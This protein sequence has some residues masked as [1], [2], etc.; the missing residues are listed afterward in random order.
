V[1]DLKPVFLHLHDEGEANWLNKYA[2]FVRIPVEDEYF[3][4]EHDGEWYKVEV[5]VH[6]PFSSE[7][8]AE[9]YAVKVEHQ[10]EVEKKV[11]TKK[12]SVRVLK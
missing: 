8:C 9:I 3:A 7:M 6:T 1:G 11:K 10:K 4:I 2:D 5:V 12:G